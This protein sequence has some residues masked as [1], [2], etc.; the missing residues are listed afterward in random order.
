MKADAYQVE[1]FYA[2]FSEVSDS[3]LEIIKSESLGLS[4]I[5]LGD[6]CYSVEDFDCQGDAEDFINVIKERVSEES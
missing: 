4:I 2:Y 3:N 5:D 1:S 6:R